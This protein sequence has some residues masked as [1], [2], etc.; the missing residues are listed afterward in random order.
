MPV[1]SKKQMRFMRGVAGGS[2][3]MKS[4]SPS[5]AMEFIE[6]TPKKK[7]KLFSSGES[8]SKRSSASSGGHSGH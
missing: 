4:L 8:K 1:K 6:K 7:R 2:I 3:R 5:M